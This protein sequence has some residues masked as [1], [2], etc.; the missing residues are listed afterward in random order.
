MADEA[1]LRIVLQDSGG[2]QGAPSGAQP[3]SY[4]P[5]QTA[6]AP[7]IL[8]IASSF[9]GAIGGSLGPTVG[10]ALD[11]VTAFRKASATA[12][13]P[14]AT[15][16]PEALPTAAIEAVPEVLPA[17]AKAIPEVLP[18]S[19]AAA[20]G[21]AM[22]GITA[23]VP[24]VAVAL[25]AKE[26]GEKINKA[27]V[28]GIKGTVGAVGAV[29]SG[30]ASSSSDPFIPIAKLGDTTSK[31]G[32]KIAEYLPVLGYLVIAT[33]EAG[34][35]VAGLMQELDKAAQRY[36]EYSPQIA[37]AQ[38]VAE[39]RHTLG[40][41]R[42]AQEV[43]HELARYVQTQGE[44]QQKF[45][46]IKVKL[47]VKLLPIVTRILEVLEM[48][49]PSGQG[50]EAAINALVTPLTA[51]PGAGALIAQVMQDTSRPPL[52]DPTSQLRDPMF[53]RVQSAGGWVPEL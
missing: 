42:R 18:S 48:V 40:D 53:E 17:G 4:K 12:G 15:I 50:I 6:E 21:R 37:Q 46:D 28:D 16:E 39:V 24:F 52:D 31:A 14:A 41:L 34:K 3:R 11:V 26:L 29:A 8:D 2:G 1:V 9:R 27:I 45:E 47:L 43:G 44:L 7:N 23:A 22:A 13:A 10:A 20:G 30:I 19:A 25:A 32:E 49:I 5:Q 36:G 38:A 35:A 51:I 33:G